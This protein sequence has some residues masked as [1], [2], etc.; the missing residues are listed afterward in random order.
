VIRKEYGLGTG[1]AVNGG[2]PKKHRGQG[3]KY[4]LFDLF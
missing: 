4:R 3:K 2:D 1:S